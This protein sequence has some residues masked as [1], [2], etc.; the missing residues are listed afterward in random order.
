MDKED[1]SE[2]IKSD[3]KIKPINMINHIN[4][5]VKKDH[6][7]LPMDI[8]MVHK[9]QHQF[10]TMSNKLVREGNILNLI[11]VTYINSLNIMFRDEMLRLETE[12]ECLL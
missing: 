11:K 10:L 12:Q 5:H 6:M 2:E 4:Q 7:I 1:L 3:N 9:I 8:E